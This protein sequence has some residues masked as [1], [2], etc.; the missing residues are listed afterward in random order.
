MQTHPL[1]APKYGIGI[2]P[3]WVQTAEQTN[4]CVFP[5]GLNNTSFPLSRIVY[6]GY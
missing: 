5:A 4:T 6:V 1:Y 2:Q 3:K